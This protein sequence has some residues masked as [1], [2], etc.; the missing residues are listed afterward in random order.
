MSLPGVHGSFNVSIPQ[1]WNPLYVKSLHCDCIGFIWAH[2]YSLHLH[3]PTWRFLNWSTCPE[4]VLLD[5]YQCAHKTLLNIRLYWYF[6]VFCVFNS[7]SIDPYLEVC[8]HRTLGGPFHKTPLGYIIAFPP[9]LP[10]AKLFLVGFSNG[11]DG[12]NRQ[13]NPFKCTWT[14]WTLKNM[15]QNFFGTNSSC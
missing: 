7:L 12:K 13:L 10:N 5:S 9:K 8:I 6:N 14:I 4:A 11:A 1:G 3:E 15:G 2:N